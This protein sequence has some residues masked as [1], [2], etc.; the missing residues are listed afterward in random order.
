VFYVYGAEAARSNGSGT[1][2]S[3]TNQFYSFFSEGQSIEVSY[4][5][6]SVTAPIV[7]FAGNEM[8][9]INRMPVNNNAQGRGDV[10]MAKAFYE[11]LAE[12]I[13]SQPTLAQLDSDQW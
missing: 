3:S 7:D 10:F 6:T 13:V 4:D 11:F 12:G 5:P 1:S 2:L 9:S 8:D